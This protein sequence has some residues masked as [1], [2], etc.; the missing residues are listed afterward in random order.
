MLEYSRFM[1]LL[2]YYLTLLYLKKSK[3]LMLKQVPRSFFGQ[4]DRIQERT[5]A[6]VQM[7]RRI[8][9]VLLPIIKALLP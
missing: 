9:N 3:V 6:V 1:I 2:P 5:K 4:V 7:R 8:P